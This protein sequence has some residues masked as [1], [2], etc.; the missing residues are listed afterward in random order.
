[1]KY[2]DLLVLGK[3]LNLTV[4]EKNLK[5]GK[6]V[7]FYIPTSKRKSLGGNFSIKDDKFINTESCPSGTQILKFDSIKKVRDVILSNIA[8][9]KSWDESVKNFE[10]KGL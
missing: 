1:M 5:Q 9:R 4:K 2:E 8:W 3:E 10:I 7:L 6:V